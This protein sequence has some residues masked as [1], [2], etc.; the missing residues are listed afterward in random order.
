[1]ANI[2][3]EGEN[4]KG[5]VTEAGWAN[6]FGSQDFSQFEKLFSED[7]TLEAPTIAKP[8]VGRKLVAA[9]YGTASKYYEYCNFTNQAAS[10]SP[11][12]PEG[13]RTWLEWEVKTLDGMKMEGFTIIDKHANG[14]IFKCRTLHYPL[15]EALLFSNHL[16]NNLQNLLGDEYFFTHEIFS[17]TREKY[18]DYADEEK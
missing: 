16:R 17:K 14:E 18:P 6:A 15:G 8:I 9:T 1:M 7:A 13:T 4:Q 10:A 12:D 3:Y 5:N 2:K 11:L